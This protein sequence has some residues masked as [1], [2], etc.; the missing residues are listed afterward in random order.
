MLQRIIQLEET[1]HFLDATDALAV[2]LCH[3]YATSSVV[4]VSKKSFK[5]WEDF[6]GSNP[7][8]L[9]R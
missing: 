3:H 2:A 9:I 1:P 8:R 6:I 5:G 7:D 4:N